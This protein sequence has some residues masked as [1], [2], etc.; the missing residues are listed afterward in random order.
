M[1]S[2][3]F[4][5]RVSGEVCEDARLVVSSIAAKPRVIS[6]V[7]A[8]VGGKPLDEAA[9][10]ALGAAAYS[11]CHPLINVAYDQDY[12]REMVPVYVRRAVREAAGV[13]G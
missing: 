3:A 12:R 6:G 4:A 7:A 1:L 13:T 10:Q 8:I 5:A 11:Q 2:V 9:A